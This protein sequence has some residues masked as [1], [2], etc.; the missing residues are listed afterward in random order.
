[1][2]AIRDFRP[3]MTAIRVLWGFRRKMTAIRALQP[4]VAVYPRREAPSGTIKCFARSDCLSSILNPSKPSLQAHFR[5]PEFKIFACGARFVATFCVIR[6]NVVQELPRDNSPVEIF[7]RPLQ[8]RD[9]WSRSSLET[10]HRLKFPLNLFKSEIR[11]PGAPS[12]Q[13]TG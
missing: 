3:K 8:E 10:I 13:F 5:S 2:T 1:M 12:R 9:P 11:D 6:Y 7:S 4:S